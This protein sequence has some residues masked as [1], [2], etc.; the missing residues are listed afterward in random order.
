[1]CIWLTIG[2][3]IAAPR[4]AAQSS[5]PTATPTALA[6][7]Y[8]AN[9][10]TLPSSLAV[11]VAVPAALS[12]ALLSVQYP[13]GWLTV[14]PDSGRAPLALTVNV[15]PTGLSPGSYSAQI[16][17]NAAGS[18]NPAVVAVTLSITN[19]PASL[20]VS[21]TST[22]YTAAPP[23]LAFTF[24]TG[25][26][27]PSPASSQLDVFS[28]G[29]TIPFNVAAIAGSSGS[30]SSASSSAGWLRVNGNNQLPGTKTSG[31]A[32]SGSFVP[33]TVTLDAVALATLNPGSYTGTISVA[34]NSSAN[35]SATVSVSLVVSAG[36]PALD[37]TTPIFPSSLV[38][39]P[40][41]NPVITIY[42]DNFFNT[43]VVTLKQAIA[44]TPPITLS[45][46]LL[47]RKVLRAVIPAATLSATGDWTLS[48]TNPSPASSP[49]QPPVST[50][51]K[52]VSATQPLITS[53]VNAGSY[54]PTAVQTGTNANPVP[55]NAT[56]VSPREIIS[57]F[58]QNL[59]PATPV[60]ATATGTP[61]LFPTTVSNID[62]V[63]LIGSLSVKAPIIMVS[64]NQVN[65][66]VPVET[67]A[68]AAAPGTAVTVTVINRTT[69][70]PLSTPPF[71]L[72]VVGSDPAVFTFGGLGKGQAAVLN[73]DAA[74]SSY[75]IN[76]TKDAAAKGS[77]IL[78]YATGLGD[79]STPM[80]NGQVAT[81]AIPLALPTTRVDI[82]GQ[83]AV[84]SYAGTSPG[85]VAGLVQINAIV[86]P[87]VRTGQAIPL[88]V[89]IGTAAT[90]RR[91]QAQVTI[92][93]K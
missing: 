53:V 57:I 21:S 24:T 46:T 35:G 76:S 69:S 60:N 62:V 34:A 80:A 27:L 84:V 3:A 36:P 30:S 22:N 68:A 85:A 23:S 82:D 61:A 43:S 63:F 49:G 79:L 65:A 14:T 13:L 91:S 10:A 15:N 56:S 25:Q 47:S 55:V 72:A 9:S 5:G 88:T 40:A 58:G 1:L 38:S 89:S 87:T 20:T 71:S 64:A 17:I 77:T 48:V 8:Q 83:P 7:S 52:V 67:A 44:T 86:P 45:S 59:G 90:A 73:F 4:A 26:T 19:P 42:G 70:V 39:G 75:V 51:L 16:V 74:S 18:S 12:S 32:L 93:V 50:T 81:T 37:A 28:T 92:G 11:Q 29:D 78:I 66:I 6:F 54:L 2:A 41:V 33:I 31:V